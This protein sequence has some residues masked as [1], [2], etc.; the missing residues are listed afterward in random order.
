[1]LHNR[2]IKW[3]SITAAVGMIA[4]APAAPALANHT[5]K[6]LTSKTTKS[7]HALVSTST[8]ALAGKA[9]APKLTSHAAKAKSHKLTSRSKKTAKRLSHK[10]KTTSTHKHKTASSAL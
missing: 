10:P 5:H 3:A 6:H 8:P 4:A 7:A 1:M 9:H 2:L